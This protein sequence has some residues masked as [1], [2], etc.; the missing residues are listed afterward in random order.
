[1]STLEETTE[2]PIYQ[3]LLNLVANDPKKTQVVKDFYASPERVLIG[4]TRLNFPVIPAQMRLRCYFWTILHECEHKEGELRHLFTDHDID[5][6][7]VD[8]HKA[9]L[10][11]NGFKDLE[12][13]DP[14]QNTDYMDYLL[15]KSSTKATNS[16][17]QARIDEMK[18][19][20]D[21][22]ARQIEEKKKENIAKAD[23][24]AEEE[25]LS[26]IDRYLA[27]PRTQTGDNPLFRL[28]IDIPTR[29]HTFIR[30]H[31]FVV[32]T[33]KNCT[34]P[35]RMRMKSNKTHFGRLPESVAKKARND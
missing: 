15:F 27:D 30:K 14:S 18:R 7:D 26:L 3:C 23:K 20:M 1:M 35:Y 34:E 29:V 16:N 25:A 32:I 6:N 2:F 13:G 4:K 11:V 19:K 33:P 5:A 31:G 17:L 10:I 21:W 9:W 24:A 12:L 8:F 28:P 22:R